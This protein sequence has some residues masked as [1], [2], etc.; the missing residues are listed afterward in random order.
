IDARRGQTSNAGNEVI[1]QKAHHH[2]RRVPTAGNQA[3]EW[4]APRTFLLDLYG[5]R[6]V[7]LYELA[8]FD[9]IDPNGSLLEDRTDYVVC[10][11]AFRSRWHGCGRIH[12]WPSKPSYAGPTG[13]SNFSFDA[14]TTGLKIKLYAKILWLVQSAMN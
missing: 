12:F 4:T 5:L 3:S 10:E 9:F 11:V 6:I 2:G 1:D 7:C 13:R 14:S 8:Q